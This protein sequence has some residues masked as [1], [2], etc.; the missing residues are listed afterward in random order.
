MHGKKFQRSMVV[1]GVAILMCAVALP[2]N[3]ANKAR[4][5]FSK[6]T[7]GAGTASVG[8]ETNAADSPADGPNGQRIK[9][10]VAYNGV[11]PTDY[12]YDLAFAN[13][14]GISTAG[15]SVANIRNLSFDFMNDSPGTGYEGAGSPRISVGVDLT[16]GSA[17]DVYLYLSAVYC[18]VPFSSP[19][20]DWSR[21]DFTGET[22]LNACTIWDNVGSYSSNGTQSAWAVYAAAHPAGIVRTAYVVMD[23]TGTAYLDRL[24][25]QNHMFSTKKTIANCPLESSC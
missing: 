15:V 16:G 18:D 6:V 23:E 17:I 24:A 20:D 11:Y 5:K 13:K 9:L 2:A 3:A 4:L 12:A 21:A 10:T 8:W 22:A 14:T 25:F 19:D 7:V 1:G